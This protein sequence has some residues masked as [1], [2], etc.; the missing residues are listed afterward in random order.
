MAGRVR[1][2]NHLEVRGSHHRGELS[3]KKKIKSMRSVVF[4]RH[5]GAA[6]KFECIKAG[7]Y[8]PEIRVAASGSSKVFVPYVPVTERDVA[9]H[10]GRFVQPAASQWGDHVF[11]TTLPERNTRK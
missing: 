3:K 10:L 11:F 8:Q 6:N 9:V 5:S 1:K 7:A 2:I 4:L